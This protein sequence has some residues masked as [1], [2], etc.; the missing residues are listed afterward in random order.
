MITAL[1]RTNKLKGKNKY[2]ME[3]NLLRVENDFLKAKIEFLENS[4][5][6]EIKESE[7]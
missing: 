4:H 2:L 7:V 3:I 5:F 6:G 1:K